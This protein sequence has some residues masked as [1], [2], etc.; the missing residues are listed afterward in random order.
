MR[1]PICFPV[2][3]EERGE[4]RSNGGVQG[5]GGGMQGWGNQNSLVCLQCLAPPYRVT[6]PWL[7]PRSGLWLIRALMARG[8]MTDSLTTISFG[9]WVMHVAL[10]P[11]TSGWV[12][13]PEEPILSLRRQNYGK[14]DIFHSAG[15]PKGQHKCHISI[16]KGGGKWSEMTERLSV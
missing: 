10:F 15:T 6:K 7:Q 4:R 9:S 14:V 3:S 1:G 11:F 13:R 5:V 12:Y 8:S 2:A 16:L